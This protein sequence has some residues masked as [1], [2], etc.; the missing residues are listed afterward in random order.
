MTLNARVLVVGVGNVL[1]GDDGFG[2]EVVKR[3]AQRKDL[4]PGAVVLETGTGGMTLVQELFNG[5]DVLMVVDAVDRGAIPGTTYL[6][7]AEVPTVAAVTSGH[8]AA[9]AADM[10]LAP[11]A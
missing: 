5:C 4:S 2:V 11:R 10:H 9:S 1:Q 6:R 7:K 3:L 8:G